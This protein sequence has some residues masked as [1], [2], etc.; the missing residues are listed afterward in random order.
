MLKNSSSKYYC[1]N[2]VRVWLSKELHYSLELNQRIE[3]LFLL[4][5]FYIV[6]ILEV[7]FNNLDP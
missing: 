4:I 3:S 5:E 7:G 6:G 1:T 2:C